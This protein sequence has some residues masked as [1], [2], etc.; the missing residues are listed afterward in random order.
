MKHLDPKFPES[1]LL[2]TKRWALEYPDSEQSTGDHI[3]NHVMS[4][5]GIRL[6]CASPFRRAKLQAVRA[7]T[8]ELR[9]IP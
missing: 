9:S 1:R 2:E 4:V 6:V 3:C 8:I 5:S 7:A